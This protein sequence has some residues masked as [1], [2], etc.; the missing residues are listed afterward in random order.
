LLGALFIN[1]SSL[2]DKA[3]LPLKS[4]DEISIV[5]DHNQFHQNRIGEVTIL[6]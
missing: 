2:R 3:T 4:K 5:I 1:R 6:A